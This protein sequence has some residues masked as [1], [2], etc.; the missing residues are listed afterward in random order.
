MAILVWNQTETGQIVPGT[1]P[2][3]PTGGSCL[4]RTPSRLKCLFMFIVFFLARD[5]SGVRCDSEASQACVGG[6]LLTH[7]CAQWLF[8]TKLGLAE[9]SQ[10]LLAL[11]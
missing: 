1:G 9:D 7:V 10:F 11:P 2:I 3:C 5:K 8:Q 6:T 4:S